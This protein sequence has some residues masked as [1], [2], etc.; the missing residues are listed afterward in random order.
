MPTSRCKV[1]APV[2][3]VLASPFEVLASL[4]EVLASLSGFRD[5]NKPVHEHAALRCDAALTNVEEESQNVKD[6]TRKN[7]RV[8][9]VVS[10][11]HREKTANATNI[12]V[13]GALSLF[14]TRTHDWIYRSRNGKVFSRTRHPKGSALEIMIGF[15]VPGT[16]R[17]SHEHDTRKAET[18]F[19]TAPVKPRRTIPQ[20]TSVRLRRKEVNTKCG[21]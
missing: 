15:H 5:G 16:T 20:R 18:S 4:C 9:L 6:Q 12:I 10:N 17:Y 14:G 1:L 11:T 19:H 8:S 3:K 7:L 2:C 13:R 21:E